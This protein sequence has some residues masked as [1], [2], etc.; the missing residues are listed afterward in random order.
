MNKPQIH[1]YESFLA[2][3]E[4]LHTRFNQQKDLITLDL[5]SLKEEIEPAAE[6]LNIAKML[7]RRDHSLGLLGKGI[8]MIVDLLVKKVILRKAGFITR[9]L[10]AFLV[11]NVV[12][13]FT[14]KKAKENYPEI[15]KVLRQT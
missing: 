6:V 15:T 3:K 5:A 11:K 12:S 8:D 4:R 9:F 14:S 7:V 13:Q 10:A 2:E 1:N